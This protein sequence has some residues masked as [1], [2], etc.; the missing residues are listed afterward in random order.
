MNAVSGLFNHPDK[1]KKSFLHWAQAFVVFLIGLSFN[2]FLLRFS[3]SATK[4]IACSKLRKL[5]TDT[6]VALCTAHPPPG[7]E[8]TPCSRESWDQECL[9][10]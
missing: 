6:P 8:G 5:I 10:R 3:S 7:G 4:F 9:M 1:I 2:S